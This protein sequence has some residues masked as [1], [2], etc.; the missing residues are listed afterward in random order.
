MLGFGRGLPD[1]GAW[2]T[3]WR[4]GPQE[5][6]AREKLKLE[7][8]KKKKLERFNSSRFNLDNLADLENLVQRRKKRLRHRVPPRKPEPLVKVSGRSG[9]GHAD[10]RAPVPDGELGEE[11]ALQARTTQPAP[12][13]PLKSIPE[14]PGMC[15]PE[16]P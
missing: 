1:P 14:P 8:E 9:L 5:A 3:D 7:E 6:V 10:A 13:E 4:R 11:W 15:P 16:M 12:G 2:P